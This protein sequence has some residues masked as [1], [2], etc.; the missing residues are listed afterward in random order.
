MDGAA[1]ARVGCVRFAWGPPAARIELTNPDDLTKEV[2]RRRA[3]FHWIDVG[4]AGRAERYA[5]QKLTH[6]SPTHFVEADGFKK[7][8]DG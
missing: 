7:V 4:R 6:T 8:G 1:P 3:V 5:L 2:V